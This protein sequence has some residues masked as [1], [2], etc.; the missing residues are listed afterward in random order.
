MA[1]I[2]LHIPF[3]KQAC[4]YCNFHFSTSLLQQEA[5]VNSIVQEIT[6]Q[7]DYLA[8]EPV[9]TIYFGG[10]TP[11]LLKEQ[12]LTALLLHLRAT[13][14]VAAD[15][16]ITLEAN[17]DDLTAE[18]LVQLKATGINRLSIGVQSFHEEDLTWMNRA[19]NSRQALD[20]IKQAQD[21]GFQNITIDLIYGGPTLTNEGW[22]QN[23]KQAIALGV[24]HL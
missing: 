20:C 10:G 24:P 3:C 11:S 18:K 19:H 12:E 14:A 7:K 21:L 16:E 4:Y 15:A 17:P 5:M 9:H 13:F 8:Q 6:L 22:E 2:Y 23:V 1:G